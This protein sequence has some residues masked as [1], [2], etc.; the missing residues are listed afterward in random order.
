MVDKRMINNMRL[1]IN[2]RNLRLET[3]YDFTITCGVNFHMRHTSLVLF[4]HYNLQHNSFNF[5]LSTT[6]LLIYK[7][8]ISRKYLPTLSRFLNSH[9][10]N[11][12]SSHSLIFPEIFIFHNSYSKQSKSKTHSSSSSCRWNL[13]LSL[14]FL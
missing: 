14:S 7:T 10:I 11:P 2:L 3:L 9:F 5:F 8:N 12:N 4:D 6:T 1:F 13:S